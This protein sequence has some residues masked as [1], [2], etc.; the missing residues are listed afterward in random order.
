[1][2]LFTDDEI[3]A[4]LQQAGMVNGSGPFDAGGG[5]SNFRRFA[6]LVVAKLMEQK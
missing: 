2:E 6:N 3:K 5:L 1:M 4:M